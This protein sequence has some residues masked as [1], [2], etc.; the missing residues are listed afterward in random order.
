MT[1]STGVNAGITEANLLGRKICEV[2]GV[3]HHSEVHK[4]QHFTCDSENSA[5]GV[6]T[7]GRG[8]VLRPTHKAAEYLNL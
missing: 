7:A 3:N 5:S 8:D 4:I 1:L 2:H 6:G